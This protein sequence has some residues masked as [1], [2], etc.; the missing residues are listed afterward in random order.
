MLVKWLHSSI[1]LSLSKELVQRRGHDHSFEMAAME[2]LAG[3]LCRASGQWLLGRDSQVPGPFQR[4][5]QPAVQSETVA[6]REAKRNCSSCWSGNAGIV[7]AMCCVCTRA[8]IAPLQAPAEA[9][10]RHAYCH[11][12]A[13]FAVSQHP[14]ALMPTER[15]LHQQDLYGVQKRF[16]AEPSHECDAPVLGVGRTALVKKCMLM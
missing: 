3:G 14:C 7:Q 8:W 11:E 1:V 15:G 2:I 6:Y 9:A 13:R 4:I 10:L 12:Y 16:T 5:L